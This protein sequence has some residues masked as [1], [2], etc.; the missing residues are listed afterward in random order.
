ME[1]DPGYAFAEH[2]SNKMLWESSRGP[3]DLRKSVYYILALKCHKAL[4]A[5]KQIYLQSNTRNFEKFP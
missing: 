5:N 2:S 3:A 4:L 1:A